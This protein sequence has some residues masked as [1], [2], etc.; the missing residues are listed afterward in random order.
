MLFNTVGVIINLNKNGNPDHNSSQAPGYYEIKI[1][2]T[3]S[4]V[5]S[6]N[7]LLQFQLDLSGNGYCLIFL[8]AAD[9]KLYPIALYSFSFFEE[10]NNYRGLSHTVLGL[11]YIIR[12]IFQN[13][14]RCIE[15]ANKQYL[16]SAFQ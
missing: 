15:P 4:W 3:C 13:E 11:C 7:V 5:T 9:R 6:I 16:K 2:F 14:V 1:L 8:K 10:I 12:L